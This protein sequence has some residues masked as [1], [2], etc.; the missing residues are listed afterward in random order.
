MLTV[1]EFIQLKYFFNLTDK[2]FFKQINH[3][4]DT[5]LFTLKNNKQA[6]R[7]REKNKL[8]EMTL[9]Q[10]ASI[11]LLETNELI[12]KQQC[13]HMLTT[14]EIPDGKI[15][16]LVQSQ[17]NEQEMVA[18]FGSLTTI[19]AETD[20]MN[21]LI[22]LD[23]SSYLNT[24]DYELEYE[25]SNIELGQKHFDALLESQTIPKRTTKNKLVRFY[26]QKMHEQTNSM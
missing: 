2:D 15:K 21:G 24:E 17:L 18:Y 6:L 3:Y 13:E 14:G 12:S 25:V 23:N 8:Y 1:D 19:R 16:S 10:P 20:Y 9:K 7:I 5:P 11:G 26:E 22:V 4:F